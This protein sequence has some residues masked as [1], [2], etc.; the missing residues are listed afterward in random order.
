MLESN[1]ALM[2]V[3][4]AFP[5]VIEISLSAMANP[6]E[7]SMLTWFVETLNELMVAVRLEEVENAQFAL[8][9]HSAITSFTLTLM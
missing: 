5:K 1:V 7:R 8:M 4:C 9:P 6:L 3:H 2:E